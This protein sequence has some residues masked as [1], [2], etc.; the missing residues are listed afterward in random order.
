MDTQLT[1]TRLFSRGIRMSS[2]QSNS[3][4]RDIE[5]LAHSMAVL[6]NTGVRGPRLARRPIRPVVAAEGQEFDVDEDS[7]VCHTDSLEQ[8]QSSQRASRGEIAGGGGA[9]G[10]PGNYYAPG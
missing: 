5:D 1:I 4:T 7:F 10:G 3:P 6:R 9:E 2:Q 8:I